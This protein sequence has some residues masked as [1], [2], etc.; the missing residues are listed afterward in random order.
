MSYGPR[1]GVADVFPPDVGRV[2][3]YVL[4]ETNTEIQM[5]F[6]W[7]YG[8][9]LIGTVAGRFEDGVN[10]TWLERS[11]DLLFPEGEYHVE[12][13]FGNSVVEEVDFQVRASGE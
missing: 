6:R 7:Y 8:E 2:Y 12:I 13:V 9:Q 3:L 4:L 10:Y 1:E 11:P 5:E